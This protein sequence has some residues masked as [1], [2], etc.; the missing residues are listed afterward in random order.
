MSILKNVKNG[1]RHWV[2]PFLDIRKALSLIYLPRLIIDF[3]KFRRMQTCE[4]APRLKDIFPCLTDRLP[5]TPFDP[6]YFFQSAWL[7]R[8]VVASAP[9]IHIDVGSSANTIATLSAM[10]PIVFVDYRPLAVHLPGLTPVAG[11]ITR[12]PFADQ[13]ITS[14]SCLHVIEHIGLGRYGDPLDPN[15]SRAAADEL[16]RIVALGGRLYLSTPV[17]RERI[18]FNAHRVFSPSTIIS[19]FHELKLLSFSL[20]DD[21]G[22]YL[23]STSALSIPPLEYGCGFFEF[24]RQ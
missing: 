9:R 24:E 8:H 23:E 6:H 21:A 19:W 13:S 20:V 18:C 3:L 7:S 15:G 22:Q 2:S 11:T 12:L 1:L 14:L 5:Q 16:Q 10:A 4:A 17:G